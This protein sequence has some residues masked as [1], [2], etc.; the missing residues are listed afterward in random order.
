MRTN[1]PEC[2]ADVVVFDGIDTVARRA[3]GG[4]RSVDDGLSQDDVPA[5]GLK[6]LGELR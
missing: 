6:F 1:L 4:E 2:R 5:I 3:V